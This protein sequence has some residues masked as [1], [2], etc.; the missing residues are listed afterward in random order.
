M[1]STTFT[2]AYPADNGTVGIDVPGTVHLGDNIRL[3]WLDDA[4]YPHWPILYCT[5]GSKLGDTLM[6]WT[7]Y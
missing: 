3:Q 2:W 1:T 4:T 7:M 6:I 5:D